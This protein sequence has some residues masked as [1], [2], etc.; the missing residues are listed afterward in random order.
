MEKAL[1]N[2]AMIVLPTGMGKTFIA[3]VVMYNFHQWYPQGKIIFVAPTRPLV[4]QQILECRKIS[5]IPASHCIELTGS[6]PSAK[7]EALWTEK[8]VIFATPQ[9]IENDLENGILPATQVKCIVI[10]EAHRAQGGYAY[11]GIVRRLHEANRN[12]FRVLA[13]SATPGSDIQKVQQ[14]MMN[15]YIGDVMFRSESSLDL[16]A[17][18]NQKISKAWTV[19]L[20]GQ[21]KR[22]VDKMIA[23]TKPTYSA[24]YKAGLTYN[25]DSI[26]RV[27]KYSLVLALQKLQSNTAGNIGR[28]KGRLSFHASAAMALSSSFELLTLYGIR[29]FYASLTRSMEGKGGAKTA[30]AGSP[31]YDLL[32]AEIRKMFGDDLEID[33]KKRANCDLLQG[34][35]KLKVVKDLLMAHFKQNQDKPDTRAIVFTKYRD[36]V[37][38]IV[39]TLKTFEPI[40]K[41]APFV[42][43]SDTQ[44]S[45]S[46]MKQKEQIKMIS[47]FKQ[48]IFNVLVATCVAEEG[49]DIGEVDLIICYD[50]TS[51]PI[52]NTQR[53]GRTGRKRSGDVQTLCTKGYEEKKLMKAGSSRRQ[54]ED[55]LYKRENYMMH[56]YRDAPRLVPASINPVCL[57]QKI[58]PV[59]DVPEEEV[60]RSGG[61]RKKKRRARNDEE[62]DDENDNEE[63]EDDLK[64]QKKKRKK[65][66]AA[67]LEQEERERRPNHDDGEDE[68]EFSSDDS[69]E[70]SRIL[71][72][73]CEKSAQQ[74]DEDEFDSDP[75]FDLAVKEIM[76]NPGGQGKP[77]PKAPQQQQVQALSS[78]GGSQAEESCCGSQY[79]MVDTGE[80]DQQVD[81]W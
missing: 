49:L 10:D 1:F 46:G 58:F 65:K 60:T 22:L 12:G 76:I 6:T 50:T 45:G 53:R 27:A 71:E 48:G 31:E 24:L 63:L 80:A 56:R 32:Q 18:K 36:S 35:P 20:S 52:S 21:H 43:Q 61:G 15:L 81:E 28:M 74:D 66:E 34:H 51:S 55:Q 38:D 67:L 2:N 14:V 39:Q 16:L 57:E 70:E 17:F 9:V 64:M 79:E 62:D 7:R 13:L 47:D 69:H 72:D 30:L 23:A 5:G 11:V 26:D 40:I 75:E 73:E 54:V 8:R 59:N 41:P 33:I 29:P 19:E 42:G 78:G 25:G 3:A 44:K 77:Q 68:V 37:C 4:A